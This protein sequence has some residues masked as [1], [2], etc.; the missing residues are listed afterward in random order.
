MLK[1][2][3]EQ[4]NEDLKLEAL[5]PNED[6]SYSLRLEPALHLTLKEAAEANITIVSTLAPLPATK[7]ED[8]FLRLMCANLFGRETG[9]AALG[10]DREEK[11]LVLVHVLPQLTYRDFHERLEDFANFAEAWRQEAVTYSQEIGK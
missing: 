10:I 5:A 2:F 11:N 4:L 1:R 9:G 6:G 8:F 3:L 7:I